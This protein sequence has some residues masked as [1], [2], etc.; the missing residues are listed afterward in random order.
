MIRRLHRLLSPLSGALESDLSGLGFVNVAMVP[1]SPL[2]PI[3]ENGHN[4]AELEVTSVASRKCV[5]CNVQFTR[6]S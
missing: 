4:V 1:A 3:V 2:P 6:P 5:V